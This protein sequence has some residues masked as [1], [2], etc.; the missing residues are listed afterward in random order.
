M[1]LC[2]KKILAAKSIIPCL[3]KIL[4]RSRRVSVGEPLTSDESWVMVDG[5]QISQTAESPVDEDLGPRPED[6]VHQDEPLLP[7]NCDRLRSDDIVI[8]GTHP[9]RAGAF[10]DVWD[11]FL[12][13][14]RVMIK[15]YRL[16]SAT[17]STQARMV[18]LRWHF[19]TIRYADSPSTTEV[20]QGS[21]GG[22]LHAFPSKH[23]P[24]PG[25]VHHLQTPASSR[26]RFHGTPMSWR[27]PEGEC[28][29]QESATG[30]TSILLLVSIF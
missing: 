14:D 13:G 2:G 18:R 6:A 29:H 19:Q 17:D 3:R 9:D 15:S 1:Q 8:S 5:D 24:I 16:Y 27:I 12:A 4:R 23:R 28:G 30:A 21:A 7:P 20:P 25:C 10:A 26:V 22:M 11:G